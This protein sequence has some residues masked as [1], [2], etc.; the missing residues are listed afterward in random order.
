M[1]VDVK[2]LSGKTVGSLELDDAVW[3]A[4]VNEHLLWEAVKWQRKAL[5][6]GFEDEEVLEE[7]QKRLEL[8]EQGKPYRGD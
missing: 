4:D 6:L 5:A 1:K 8:Y 2:D 3:A 7:V